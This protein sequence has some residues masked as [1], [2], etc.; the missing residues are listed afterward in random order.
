[1]TKA[2]NAISDMTDY[3]T[4]WAHQIKTPIAAMRLLLQSNSETG[5]NTE[6]MMELFKI[7]QYV[8][9]VLVYMRASGGASDYVIKKY[10]MDEIIKGAIR[11]FSR[12][13]ILK[14]ISLDY[15]VPKNMVITDEK[16]L[17]FVI[18]QLL[19]NAIKYTPSNGLI[20][21]YM[22]DKDV[23]VI[24]DNGIGIA[25]EDLPRVFDKGY[26][27]FNGRLERKSTG[28][29]LYLCKKILDALGHKIYIVSD[30]GQGTKVVLNLKAYNTIME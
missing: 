30:E 20:K 21:I 15:N 5:N 23:L 3:Y 6:L 24:E 25:Q 12:M 17:S 4:M 28:I 18:E 13:F 16:W 9:M 22:E 27:G 2:D 26:T 8:D 29:G 1:M 10:D 14:R 19:S 7:E 11:K